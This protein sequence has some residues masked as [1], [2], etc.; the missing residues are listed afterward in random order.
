MH[1][2]IHTN[3]AGNHNVDHNPLR[4]KYSSISHL[5]CC[6]CNSNSSL[7]ILLLILLLVAVDDYFL[8]FKICLGML[9]PNLM[10]FEMGEL[11]WDDQIVCCENAGRWQLQNWKESQCP[12]CEQIWP[13]QRPP[14]SFA[15][16]CCVIRGRKE[17]KY[18]WGS[19]TRYSREKIRPCEESNI[20]IRAFLLLVFVAP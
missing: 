15:Q 7:L 2:H 17:R 12:E 14:P 16:S 10:D 19:P 6:C 5:S 4:V 13:F 8:A 20:C 18:L 9:G 11:F 1:A 3:F